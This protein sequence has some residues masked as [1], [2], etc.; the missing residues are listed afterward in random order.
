MMFQLPHK[1]AIWS[2]DNVNLR[3]VTGP[4]AVP[5]KTLKLTESVFLRGSS[6][7]VVRRLTVLLKLGRRLMGCPA[8]V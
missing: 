1:S 6:V 8:I 3:T 4:V 2:P 5:F 7:L